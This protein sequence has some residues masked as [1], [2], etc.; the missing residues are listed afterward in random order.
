[1]WQ[2]VFAIRVSR[3]RVCDQLDNTLKSVANNVIVVV[4]NCVLL[5]NNNIMILLFN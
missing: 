4:C 1:M 2:Y 5:V 3:L